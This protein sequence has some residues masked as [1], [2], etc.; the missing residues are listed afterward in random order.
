MV[1]LDITTITLI[2]AVI[3]ILTVFYYLTRRKD[4]Y[5]ES[6]P[7][8]LTLLVLIKLNN[9]FNEWL[10]DLA[11]DILK[12]RKSN[13]FSVNL[14][15]TPT[16]IFT[17]DVENVK[18]VLQT[19]FDN[20]IKG[21]EFKKRMD[22]FLG[23][24]IFNTD[25]DKWYHHRKTSA[26]LFNLNIFK[27]EVMT[28]FNEHL[29]EVIDI[30][31]R[32]Q[33]KPF[34]IQRLFHNFTLDSIGKIAF[35][36]EIGA[37]KTRVQFADDFDYVQ[38]MSMDSIVDPF[39]RVSRYLTP[40]GWKYFTCIRRMDEFAYKIIA[41]RR[42][43]EAQRQAERKAAGRSVDDDD[44]D[45]GDMKRDASRSGKGRDLVSLYLAREEEGK[46]LS[47]KDLRDII[48]NFIIAGRDT[49]AQALSWTIFRL[50]TVPDVQKRV[51]DE[52]RSVLGASSEWP[53][54]EQLQSMK[55]LDAVVM[56]AVRLHPSV[57]KE[58]KCCV[59]KEQ[60]PDGTPVN[61]GDHVVFLPWLMARSEHMWGADCEEFKPERFLGQPKPSPFLYTAFQAGPRTCLGQ[62]LALLEMKCCL[63]RLL[64]QFEFTLEQSAADVTYVTSLTLPIKNGLQVSARRVKA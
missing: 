2:P 33:G 17:N 29:D 13:T 26:N 12:W 47:D 58:I 46:R 52:V 6:F 14:I 45:A 63:A 7:Y 31:D 4:A 23:D 55:Y 49:T 19:K 48:L 34:N 42:R 11:K 51:R 61:P 53:T 3:V 22:P 15:F 36:I 50:C 43:E 25:G 28:A 24:G 27:I 8:Q 57:P 41:D 35:G 37:L 1:V 54:F 21:N 5:P 30:L 60:L 40:A 44:E 20:F 38:K 18:Y 62:N 10:Q 32:D 56:E 9:G 59:A 39:W 16:L 64:Q